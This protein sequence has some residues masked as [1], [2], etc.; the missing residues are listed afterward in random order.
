MAERKRKS[1]NHEGRQKR[2]KS[3]TTTYFDYNLLFLIVFLICFGLVMLYSSSS[4]LAANSA[5]YNYDGAFYLKKQ[6]RN[7]LIGAAGMAF[8]TFADYRIWRGWGWIA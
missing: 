4:Y 2:R 8:F 3:R 7:A 1:E 5:L 6:L